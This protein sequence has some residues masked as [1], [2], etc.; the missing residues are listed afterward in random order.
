[1]KKLILAAIA[2]LFLA[3]P[4]YSYSDTHSYKLISIDQFAI[5]R[6][7]HDEGKYRVQFN[8]H[9][10][11]VSTTSTYISDITCS[12]DQTLEKWVIDRFENDKTTAFLVDIP[13]VLMK[14][15]KDACV[16]LQWHIGGVILGKWDL[17]SKRWE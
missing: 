11:D 2:S 10:F 15:P 17:N 9:L 14:T 16:F 3:S 8:F 6:F 5:H 13:L 12:F 1:M 4:A 7:V